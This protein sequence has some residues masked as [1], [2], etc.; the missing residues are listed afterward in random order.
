MGREFTVEYDDFTGGHFVGDNDMKQPFNT[1]TGENICCT[2]DEG[3]LMPDGGWT[4]SSLVFQRAGAPVLVHPVRAADSDS[5]FVI[6]SQTVYKVTAAGAV[7]T[8][9]ALG[10]SPGTLS[11]AC[12]IQI[13]GSPLLILGKGG[14]ILSMNAAGTLT[15]T[16]FFMAPVGAAGFWQW[17]NWLLTIY[18]SYIAWTDAD[19]L[20]STS[21][22]Y[23][24]IP[25]YG[26]II[27]LIPT[28]D[29]LYAL[30]SDGWWAVTGVLGETTQLRRITKFG[31]AS[32]TTNPVAAAEVSTGIAHASI[33]G[34]Q[35][36]ILNGGIVSPFAVI[37]NPATSTAVVQ[38]GDTIMVT[39]AAREV[40]IWSESRRQW[41]VSA[42]I[43]GHGAYALYPVE[44]HS[45]A[46]TT[47]A[48]L[49]IVQYSAGNFRGYV[50]THPKEITQ[51]LLTGGGFDTATVQ[52]ADYMRSKEFR[53]KEMLVEVDKGTVTG[54]TSAAR[55][56]GAC[57][58][59]YPIVG[60]ADGGNS[61]QNSGSTVQEVAFTPDDSDAGDREMVR[62]RVNDAGPTFSAKP[63]L[64]LRGVKLRRVILVCEDA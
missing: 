7:S 37:K 26:D 42:P 51:P 56:V 22:N 43:L 8:F 11:H 49:G 1:W 53:V 57:V 39:N 58:L 60:V 44:D 41:R 40:Y 34:S 59:T 23:L 29:V 12:H 64:N 62:F 5:T 28:S 33:S 15:T 24:L 31:G 55:A 21:T 27:T 47:V 25:S 52:L 32:T 18:D 54:A 61:G 9:T 14:S 48:A 2:A 19:A 30:T 63:V 46:T 13:S 6:E 17:K 50:Y 38:G 35:V 45:A 3:F 4:E 20:T 10:T 16:G 36:R